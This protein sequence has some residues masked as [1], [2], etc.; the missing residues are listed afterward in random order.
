M[1]FDAT[2]ALAPLEPL[3]RQ[4]EFL[5]SAVDRAPHPQPQVIWCRVSALEDGVRASATAGTFPHDHIAAVLVSDHF[6]RR[7][8]VVFVDIPRL[9]DIRD[10]L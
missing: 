5:D 4:L 7:L 8:A 6:N 9:G 10:S 2:S 3:D 1:I